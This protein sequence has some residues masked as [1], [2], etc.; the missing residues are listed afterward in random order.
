M[1]PLAFIRRRR[2]A[3]AAGI[4]ISTFVLSVILII[5]TVDLDA[6]RRGVQD[7]AADP[8]GWAIVVAALAAAFSLRALA[9]TRVLD[10]L[11]FPQALSAVHLTLAAN[12]LLPLRLGEAMR[13]VSV[14]RRT[15]VDPR[16]A[17]ASTVALRVG[18]IVTLLA[19]G[20]LAAV[21]TLGRDEAYTVMVGRSRLAPWVLAAILVV[22][23][24]VL[25]PRAGRI[26]PMIEPTRRRL[27]GHRFVG[28]MLVASWFC[29]AVVVWQVARWFDIDLQPAEALVVLA[30][31]V[32]AQLIAIAPGGIGTYEA[33]ATA[34][35]MALGVARSEAMALA[36]G[37]HGTKTL[38]SLGTGAI[39]A[40]WPNPSILGRVRLPRPSAAPTA[41]P[42]EASTA[43]EPAPV[44][45][46]LP[47]L[48]EAP[49]IADVIKRA[50]THVGPHPVEVLVIDDGST[51]ATADVARSSQAT[52][53]EHDT[54]RG[55]GAA[56]RTGL[57]AATQRGAV[58]VAFCDADGEYD[59][60]ALADLIAPILDGD[61]H[62]VVGSRFAGNIE[63]MQ[64]HRRLGNMALTIMLRWITRVPLTDGQSGYRAF[65][66]AA[67]SAADVAH[68]YNYAQ[69]LTI[70]LLTK[71]YGYAEV[72]IRYGF[73]TSGQ[74]FV[75]LGPYLMAVVPTIW[76]QLNAA[77]VTRGPRI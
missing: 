48:N 49:R 74:S 34:A 39:A 61:A 64:P 60:A 8:A 65:S 41:R 45:L 3:I 68:D 23:A 12:H 50:P 17:L 37:L 75:R 47:A 35:L 44:V 63:T 40:F 19:V 27:R 69:V 26:G 31:A 62:Y 1:N 54:N 7:A 29:E 20:G 43:S 72:P 9:W 67:A 28:P 14:V 71:G 13:V 53:V 33:S 2:P 18:D 70:D 10:R 59:P 30:V 25:I 36:V 32:S 73:R 21:A 46:F 77:P 11:P 51:D 6:L 24:L 55:L 22:A 66:G 57:N 42:I 52:V 16:R 38:Y 58:A 56:V 76:R 15:D 4:V 5:G